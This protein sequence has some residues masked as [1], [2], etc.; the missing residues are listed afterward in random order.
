MPRAAGGWLTQFRAV[1]PS[2]G[3]WFSEDPLETQHRRS[4]FA[5]VANRVMT[6]VDPTGLVELNSNIKWHNTLFDIDTPCGTQNT[7]GGCWVN[8][9]WSTTCDCDGNECTGVYKAKARAWVGGD[10]WVYTGRY[11]YKGRKPTSDPSVRSGASAAYHELMH[12]YA[13][14]AAGLGPLAA[15]EAQTFGSE[16][17]CKSACAEARSDSNA[18]FWAVRKAGAWW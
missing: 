4:P 5:Y 8:A 9:Y 12:V 18:R 7:A 10:I 1:D 17:Q 16:A 13:A 11:P 3:R 14:T 2:L 15:V 6:H